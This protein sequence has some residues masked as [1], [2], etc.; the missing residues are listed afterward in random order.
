MAKAP[1]GP[2]GRPRR[3]GRTSASPRCST[4]S[5]GTRRSIVAPVAGTT[6]DMLTA[7]ASWAD[8]EFTMVDT[9]G[10][11]GATT[12]PLHAL[13][14]EHG[15]KALETADL[16]VFVVDG[17]EGLVP[18]DERIAQE[19]RALGRPVI[20]A[21]NKTDD[22]RSGARWSFISSGSSPC[23]RSRPSTATAWPSCSTR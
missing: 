14:V 22:K 21:V 5:P 18:G 10:L 19:V 6:R 7:P 12:D 11:F 20:L 13:V 3:A 15:L 1:R 9:G 16:V 2:D 4:A 23:S 8:R 17:R